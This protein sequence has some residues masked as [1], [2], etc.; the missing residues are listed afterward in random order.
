MKYIFKPRKS[1]MEW[2]LALL[3]NI[4]DGGHWITDNACYHVNKREKILTVIAKS[5][6]ISDPVENIRRVSV[7]CGRIGWKVQEGRMII[8]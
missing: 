4:K 2:Q 7:V 6:E 3:R 5:D 8:R 1:D